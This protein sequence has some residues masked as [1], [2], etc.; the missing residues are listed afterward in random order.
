MKKKTTLK[1]IATELGLSKTVVSWVL[2]GQ[3]DFRCISQ[4][5]Q[6]LIEEKAKKMDYIP[7]YLARSLN[8]GYSG[9]LGLIM[10]S[11]SD[12]FYSSIAG[13]ITQEAENK[14]YT[15]LLGSSR[16][17]IDREER[18]IREFRGHGADGILL[19]STKKRNR[20]IFS[21]IWDE[22][23]FVLFDRYYPEIDT[24][25]VIINNQEASYQLVKHLI[26]KGYRHIAL[27]MTASHLTTIQFRKA[28]YV[29]AMEESGLD[30]ADF[31]LDV[32]IE[33]YRDELPLKLAALFEQ[34]PEV[35]AF[36][37]TTQLLAVT[38]FQYF[39]SSG[40]DLGRGENMACIHMDN[41]FPLVAPEISYAIQPVNRMAKKGIEL[42]DGIIK[43]RKTKSQAD[44]SGA[45]LDCE[46]V[47][48]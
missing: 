38:T 9:M 37:F 29:K 14:G 25:Y 28:G 43:A 21:M 2:S 33:N 4:E 18:L 39:K 48:R 16:S 6:D 46:L 19:A 26:A 24:P 5:T 36:F 3:G 45:T 22:Y 15:I 47:L 42:L 7:N 23:P 8:S 31:I 44:V 10:P 1:D 34:H 30:T 35:D 20:E 32:N 40:R 13:H 11:I 12:P 17:D 27:C 41:A